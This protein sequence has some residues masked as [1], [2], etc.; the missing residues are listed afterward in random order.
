LLDPGRKT[1]YPVPAYLIADAPRII[2]AIAA[3]RLMFLTMRELRL[4]A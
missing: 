2:I 3:I 1:Q 4:E